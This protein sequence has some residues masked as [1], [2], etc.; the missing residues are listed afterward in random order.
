MKRQAWI[1][2]ITTI[3]LYYTISVGSSL[4][5]KNL[6]DYHKLG[7]ANGYTL[8]AKAFILG[9][10]HLPIT[11]P[12]GL[13]KL[14]DP[15]NPNENKQYILDS[16]DLSLYNGKYYM[17]F[18]PLPAIIFYIIP[19]LMNINLP[20]AI[21]IILLIAGS[22]TYATML[23]TELKKEYYP[24]L[25]KITVIIAYITLMTGNMAFHLLQ[26]PDMY[27]LAISSAVFFQIAALYHLNAGINRSLKDMWLFGLYAGL[28][29]LSRPNTIP[30]N[31]LLILVSIAY[32]NYTNKMDLKKWAKPILKPFL[33]ILA[34]MLVYNTIRFENPLEFGIHYQLT[35][36]HPQQNRPAIT[37][38]PKGIYNYFMRIPD[39]TKEYPYITPNNL[40]QHQPNWAKTKNRYYTELTLAHQIIT[41][42]TLILF[43]TPP[44]IL[45]HLIKKDN[46]ILFISIAQTTVLSATIL[47]LLIFPVAVM[48]Y[49]AD[50]AT[51]SITLS[52]LIWWEIM[53]NTKKG[54]N[55]LTTLMG[56]TTLTGIY[57]HT[58]LW[59]L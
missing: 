40:K 21:P 20:Q 38:I 42:Y 57:I 31:I 59:I 6:R 19:T 13:L 55:I 16:Y 43:L 33:T 14:N 35:G 54:R 52:T 39:I 24:K 25:P 4:N 5:P 17:Y 53:K 3:L 9:Q 27:E 2:F 30:A 22:V 49:I 37:N 46:R 12:N 10:T 1:L 51:I 15:Y 8:L 34:I 18:S 36:F 58:A 7:T 29:S 47:T 56:A 32:L 45:T 44:L 23:L 50:Y 48:R 41:P 28:T 26:R 11:P